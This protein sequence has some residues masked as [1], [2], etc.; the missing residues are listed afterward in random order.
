VPDPILADARL[1]WGLP[2]EGDLDLN[3][4][5]RAGG[6]RMVIGGYSGAS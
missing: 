2:G 1:D 3:V 6:N 4:A 5:A